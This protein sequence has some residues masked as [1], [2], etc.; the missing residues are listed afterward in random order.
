MKT[1]HFIR[2][3]QTEWNKEQRY[4]GWLN[5]DLTTLGQQQACALQG[6][7]DVQV[8]FCS[9][10]GRA[11]D[12]A[13]LAFPTHK[14]QQLKDLREIYLGDWQGK[15]KLELQY[16]AYFQTYLHQPAL[17]QAQSQESFQRVTQ[18]MLRAFAYIL[19]S[20]AE[21]IA[22]VGHGVSLFCLMLAL[23]GQPLKTFEHPW[24]LQS[25]RAQT[26]YVNDK[27]ITAMQQK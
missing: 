26:F 18:R 4:Q 11:V 14:I 9:D 6:T 27:K 19:S 15:T 7:L 16:D 1:I 12:T 5:S 3:G 21:H 2:H 24:M 22:V 13:H 10:Q 20:P 8:V 23:N 17:F 25:C